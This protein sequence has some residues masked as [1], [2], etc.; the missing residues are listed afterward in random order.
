[1]SLNKVRVLHRESVTVCLCAGDALLLSPRNPRAST[2]EKAA[3]EGGE[4]TSGLLCEET[5]WPSEAWLNANAASRKWTQGR[6]RRG[7][8]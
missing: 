7:G 3:L 1:M 4:S 6:G 5:S 2:G 8:T